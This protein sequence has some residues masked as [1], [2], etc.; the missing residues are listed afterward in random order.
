MADPGDLREGF[1]DKE[2]MLETA[3]IVENDF[4]NLELAGVGTNL[5]CKDEKISV[6]GA[7]SDHTIL[8]VEEAGDICVGDTVDFKVCYANLVYLTSS[9]NI[10]KVYI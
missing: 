7:S 1:W 4:H 9:D 2:E 10:N 5:V 3:L 8:D 6:I